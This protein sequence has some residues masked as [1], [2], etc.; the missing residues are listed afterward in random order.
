MQIHIT[1]N[2]VEIKIL[3]YFYGK[4]V[5][6]ENSKRIKQSILCYECEIYWIFENECWLIRVVMAISSKHNSQY[7]YLTW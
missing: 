7:Y 5:M 1:L 4:I 6:R 3:K 2:N